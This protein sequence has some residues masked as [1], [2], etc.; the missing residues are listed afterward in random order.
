MGNQA[1]TSPRQ[2]GIGI[3]VDKQLHVEKLSDGWQIEH[4]NPLKE[5]NISWVN[6]D[7]L[8]LSSKTETT[9]M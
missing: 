6:G 5:D 4:Q 3:C 9:Q 1:T 2:T 7:K 8:V